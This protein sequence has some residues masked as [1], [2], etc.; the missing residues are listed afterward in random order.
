MVDA[1]RPPSSGKDDSDTDAP[2]ARKA[3]RETG[4]PDQLK[5]KASKSESR[6]D[7][8]QDEAVEESFPASDP[9]T[10]KQIT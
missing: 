5:D 3:D 2:F 4:K 7:A 6:Q 10:P 9:P 8:L 1:P